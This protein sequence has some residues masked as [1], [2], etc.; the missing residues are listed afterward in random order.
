MNIFKM[1]NLYPFVASDFFFKTTP[2]QLITT[3]LGTRSLNSKIM[4]EF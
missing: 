1:G 3:K 2:I 4:L